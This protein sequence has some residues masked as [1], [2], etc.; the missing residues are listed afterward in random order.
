MCFANIRPHLNSH[1]ITGFS[2]T[3]WILVL[4]DEIGCS[5]RSFLQTFGVS[6]SH[7][8]MS[9]G[10]FR[11]GP[12]RSPDDGMSHSIRQGTSLPDIRKG[13]TRH[14]L[15]DLPGPQGFFL[16]AEWFARRGSFLVCE[17]LAW[18]QT[19]AFCR[20]K[21]LQFRGVQCPVQRVQ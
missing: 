16:L 18:V 10:L 15:P 7:L 13:N 3:L 4:M 8:W 19:P 11:P 21:A 9:E 6:L 1:A 2:E 12:T 17:G 5:K 14:G 20:V